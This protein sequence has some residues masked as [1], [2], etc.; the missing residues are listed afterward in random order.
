MHIT[1][2]YRLLTPHPSPSR[3][4]VHGDCTPGPVLVERGRVGPR[5]G[6]PAGHRQPASHLQHSRAV[7]GA[8][9]LRTQGMDPLL[10]RG[11]VE[12]MSSGS[13]LCQVAP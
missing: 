12:G 11:A 7:R 13:A 9:L 6:A 2:I 1:L 3:L 4:R 5:G 10:G 8:G